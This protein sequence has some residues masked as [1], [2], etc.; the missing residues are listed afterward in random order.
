MDVILLE[1]IERLGKMGDVVK[2]K[3]GFARNFLLPQKKALRATAENLKY[4][5]SQRVQL[6]SVN[7]AQRGDAEEAAKRL[8]GQKV[9]VL[10][11]AGESGQLYGSVTTR[12]ITA[13]LVAAGFSVQRRQVNLATPIKS[14]GI[15]P[16]RVALHPEVAATVSVNVA[17]SEEEAEAQATAA[18]AP[19]EPE[20]EE[21]AAAK[22]KRRKK[23]Q[24]ELAPGADTAFEAPAE[25]KA[26]SD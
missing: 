13:A 8:D 12:D 2:V 14:L 21:E 7:V 25:P 18:S 10:R 16:V 20:P 9:V 17:K 15:Y 1:R 4:F 19:P 22:P 24:A 3:P 11:Q 26:E 23:Q 5:E 6:E